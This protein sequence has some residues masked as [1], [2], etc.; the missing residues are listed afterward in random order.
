[1]DPAVLRRP[2]REPESLLG[3][4]GVLRDSRREIATDRRGALG[5]F[6]RRSFDFSGMEITPETRPIIS[7]EDITNPNTHRRRHSVHEFGPVVGAVGGTGPTS[8]ISW[9]SFDIGGL[10]E[11]ATE[12]LKLPSHALGLLSSWNQHSNGYCALLF[13]KN[14]VSRVYLDFVVV[15]NEAVF[16]AVSP[17]LD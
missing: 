8:L 1:M 3:I 15:K 13:C 17:C 12:I 5:E 2:H 14:L 4:E 6:H 11:A 9:S 16:I 10:G 7:F